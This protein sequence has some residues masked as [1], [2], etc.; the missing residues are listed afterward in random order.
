[1]IAAIAGCSLLLRL[2]LVKAL[3]WEPFA[4]E[5]HQDIS[6][7]LLVVLSLA[8]FALSRSEEVETSEV[9]TWALAYQLFG[10]ACLAWSQFWGPHDLTPQLGQV[11]FLGVWIVLFPLVVPAP[12]WRNTAVAFVSAT[13]P[14]A[15]H[16]GWCANAGEELPGGR[17]VFGIFFPYLFCAG[18]AIFTARI[19]Y[20][21][22]ESASD[23]QREAARLGAYEL[24]EL[25][26]AGG[27][28]E[29]WRGTHG[30]L[31]R[32]AAIKLI[33]SNLL[34]GGNEQERLV[35]LAR[36]ERE[37]KITASLES[38]HTIRVFDYG[39]TANGDLYYAMELLGGLDLK[40][41]IRGFGA[42]P[43]SRAV[44]ILAQVCES[45]HEAHETGLV[46]RD[47]KPAN[48]Q[49][50]CPGQTYD[51]VKVLDFGLVSTKGRTPN[52]PASAMRLTGAGFVVGT[53][54]FLAPEQGLGRDDVDRRADIYAVGCL[55]FWLLTGELV[56][57]ADSAIAILQAHISDTPEPPSARTDL[58][59]PAAL[60]RLILKCL[61]KNPGDRPQTAAELAEGLA[62]CEGE[63]KPWTQSDAARWWREN[64]SRIEALAE[65]RKAKENKA[66]QQPEPSAPTASNWL[67]G[68]EVKD[69]STPTMTS[70][71]PPS[72]EAE[73]GI[74]PATTED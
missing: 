3:G 69:G 11:T 34:D 30:L 19:G 17:E 38:P 8:T 58:A 70:Q 62:A 1:M 29:V 66:D 49:L 23:A 48:V 9:M 2:V 63:L 65:A 53:P 18:L 6:G 35:S 51:F 64:E 4:S 50:S 74:N 67:A 60:D 57:K 61:A 5:V 25:L 44:R 59:I 47:I 20:G 22:E 46:H 68:I 12:L 28:G 7:G 14:L 33:K 56:F 55:G 26:G 40:G 54:A 10:A 43:A 24:V 73:A 37:A 31:A 72:M 52:S 21:I 42:I 71:L 39:E 27:M 45:L 32:P 13:L 15:V 41:L 36:F 16:A